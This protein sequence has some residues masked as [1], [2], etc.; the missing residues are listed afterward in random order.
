MTPTLALIVASAS[1]GAAVHTQAT[2]AHIQHTLRRFNAVAQHPVPMPT[3]ADLADLAAGEV[4][5]MVRRRPDGRYVVMGVARTGLPKE[6]VWV[7]A[8]DPHFRSSSGV[9]APLHEADHESVWYQW[10]DIPAPFADRHWV[11][12]VWD[13]TGLAHQSENTMWEHPWALDTAAMEDARRVVTAGGV[14][15]VTT[16]LFDAAIETPVNEGA[17]DFLDLGD[18]DSLYLYA[19]V[20][21]TGGGI[22]DRLVAAFLQAK[23]A[24]DITRVVDRARHHIVE[25]YNSHHEAILG[26]NGEAVARFR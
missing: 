1:A 14:D 8:L 5:S 6:Q 23:M 22:P 17:K 25:H 21:D 9:E 2:A 11:V 10:A 24:D 26:A 16:A 13:N 18:G 15:G 19:V 3:D 12:R 20:T 7:A 4:V